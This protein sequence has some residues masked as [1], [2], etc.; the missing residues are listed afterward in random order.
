MY[1]VSVPLCSSYL[2][3]DTTSLLRMTKD[4]LDKFETQVRQSGDKVRTDFHTFSLP[5]VIGQFELY[6]IF[7][8][9]SYSW[10]E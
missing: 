4:D 8:P 5:N 3:E 10:K 9:G 7:R 2:K 6:F 1:L